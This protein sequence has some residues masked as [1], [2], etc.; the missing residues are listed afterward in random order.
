MLQS[1]SMDWF[2]YD[3]GLRHERVKI[4]HLSLYTVYLS[5]LSINLWCI[6]K[7]IRENFNLHKGM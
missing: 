6:L 3:N 2:L 7:R 1:K 4:L 5:F